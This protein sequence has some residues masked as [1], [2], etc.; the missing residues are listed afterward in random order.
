MLSIGYMYIR[1]SSSALE[2]RPFSRLFKAL[3]DETRLRIVALLSHGELCV[4]HLEDALGLSQPRISRHL[5]TLRASGVVED[6]REGSWVYYRLVTQPD[7]DCER[8]LRSLVKA[9][10]EREVLRRDRA[11]LVRTR[12]PRACKP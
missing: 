7:A 6:R 8:Q 2:V 5:A 3:A 9:F 12:G 11:R 1:M 10:A 4:C